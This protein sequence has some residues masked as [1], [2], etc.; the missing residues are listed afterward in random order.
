M[1][2]FTFAKLDEIW[3]FFS[4]IKSWSCHVSDTESD[5]RSIRC[6][7]VGPISDNA[8]QWYCKRLNNYVKMETLKIVFTYYKKNKKNHG[9]QVII[10]KIILSC[11]F[12]TYFLRVKHCNFTCTYQSR[13]LIVILH[14]H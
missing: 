5:T 10:F 9:T 14:F 11:Y 13:N 8:W 3:T 2:I 7:P 4:T 12:K 1:L 6:T